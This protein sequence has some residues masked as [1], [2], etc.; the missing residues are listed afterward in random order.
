[1]TTG[2]LWK[3]WILHQ[4]KDTENIHVHN[5][6]TLLI[7]KLLALSFSHTI[8][9]TKAEHR[10]VCTSDRGGKLPSKQLS[11]EHNQRT[12]LSVV[13]YVRLY[14]KAQ[15][16]FVI[17]QNPP[18]IMNQIT[19]IDTRDHVNTVK[20]CANWTLEGWGQRAIKW[21]LSQVGYVLFLF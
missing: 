3:T 7:L 20:A 11:L 4:S 9:Q 10:F 5:E 2:I 13:R 19:R 6:K 16:S 14:N 8:W 17:C 12:I 21:L 18:V 15:H 1:M